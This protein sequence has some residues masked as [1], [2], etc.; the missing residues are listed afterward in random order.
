[1]IRLQELETQKCD[2][3]QTEQWKDRCEGWKSFLNYKSWSY[4]RGLRAPLNSFLIDKVSHIGQQKG[5]N[6]Y[7]ISP[8][9]ILKVSWKSVTSLQ[10]S[11]MYLLKSLVCGIISLDDQD[12]G[13]K[14]RRLQLILLKIGILHHK[15]CVI[16]SPIIA[17]GYNTC[18]ARKFWSLTHVHHGSLWLLYLCRLHALPNGTLSFFYPHKFLQNEKNCTINFYLIKCCCAWIIQGVKK[19][20]DSLTYYSMLERLIF[21]LRPCRISRIA[22]FNYFW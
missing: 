20:M 1:M 15:M 3:Q 4:Y 13:C 19:R 12:Y 22:I 7:E 18:I 5:T 11:S 21:F 9:Y 17:V 6:I 10:F 2:R 8:K 16:I 14:F